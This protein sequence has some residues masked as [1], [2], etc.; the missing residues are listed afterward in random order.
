MGNFQLLLN[1]FYTTYNKKILEMKQ[2]QI[3]SSTITMF[4][5]T[6]FTI[7]SHVIYP[8]HMY[9]QNFLMTEKRGQTPL[10]SRLITV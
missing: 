10:L 9:L 1:G 7:Q 8:Q 5:A 4:L 6:F 3:L 2:V